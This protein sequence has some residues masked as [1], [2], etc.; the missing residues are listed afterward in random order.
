MKEAGTV[1]GV[2]IGV[3]IGAAFPAHAKTYVDTKE[4]FSIA[5]ASGWKLAPIPGDTTGM[6]FSKR[7]GDFPASMRI[8]VSPLRGFARLDEGLRAN[9]VPFE[10]EVGFRRGVQRAMRLGEHGARRQTFTL[11]AHGDSRLVREISITVVHAYGFLY[12]VTL[13]TLEDKR[14]L[15]VQDF[16]RMLASF[17]PLAG[18]E[19]AEPLIGDWLSPDEGPPLWL[20]ADNTF[21]LGPLKGVWLA[22]GGRLDL[23]LPQ[24]REAYRYQVAGRTL[25][26]HSSNLD[27]PR[28]YRRGGSKEGGAAAFIASKSPPQNVKSL[29]REALMGRWKVVDAPSVQPLVL[30]LA[31][32]GTV[33][34]GPLH[35]Q[36]RY[37]NGLLTISTVAG[38]TITYHVSLHDERLRMGGGDLAE[39]ILLLRQK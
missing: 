38:P 2:I 30:H 36:W 19:I 4:R 22:D 24:G 12:V 1:F 11:F 33:S 28:M 18:R 26:L 35:G 21:E 10:A 6:V 8:Q 14:R 29:T 15:F 5:L 27:E 16:E 32:S 25:M 7:H 37:K 3:L 34:F 20:R 39:E 31:P 23:H 9:L 13:D 17:K